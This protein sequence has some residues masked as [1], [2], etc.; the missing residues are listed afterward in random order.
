MPATTSAQAAMAG[1][2]APINSNLTSNGFMMASFPQ[3]QQSLPFDQAS[4]ATILQQQ[5]QNEIV[6]G[7]LAFI[8]SPSLFW[9]QQQII[10]QNQQQQQTQYEWLQNFV[11]PTI[12]TQY[13]P[14]AK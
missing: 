7:N 6:S 8:Q 5:Q 3:F 1:N 2:L 13:F 14:S 9:P 4:I 10:Q 11:Y 12:G